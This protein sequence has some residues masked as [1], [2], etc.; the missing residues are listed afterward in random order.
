MNNDLIEKE[1]KAI[2]GFVEKGN[3]K[4]SKCA[5]EKCEYMRKYRKFGNKS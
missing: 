2:E 3:E 5:C 4:M 1:K